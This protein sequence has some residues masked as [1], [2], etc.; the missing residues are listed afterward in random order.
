[1]L[2]CRGKVAAFGLLSEFYLRTRILAVTPL[3]SDGIQQKHSEQD[4]SQR[5]SEQPGLIA[6]AE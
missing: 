6:H 3:G 1:V 5:E 4:A 2:L